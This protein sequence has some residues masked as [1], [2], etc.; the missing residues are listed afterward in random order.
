M[1]LVQ[2]RAVEIIEMSTGSNR[3]LP[4]ERGILGNVAWSPD[5]EYLAVMRDDEECH[6]FSGNIYVIRVSDNTET[7]VSK[8]WFRCRSYHSPR[9]SPDGTKVI[10][11]AYR[12]RGDMNWL[13]PFKDIR[14]N[15]YIVNRDGSGQTNLSANED[16]QDRNPMWCKDRATK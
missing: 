14:D 11:L 12:S 2:S 13:S 8:H 9:W 1:A 4:R 15:I 10:F 3:R 5:G 7:K 6:V 16:V